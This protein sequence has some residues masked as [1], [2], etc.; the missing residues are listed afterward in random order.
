MAGIMARAFSSLVLAVALASAPALADTYARQPIDVM[1]YDVDIAFADDFAFSAITRIDVLVR[2]DTLAGLRL[3]LA[4]PRVEAV[5]AGERSLA[6]RQVPA[7]LLI[8]LDRP[9]ARGEIARVSVRYQGRPDGTIVRTGP[10]AHG[11]PVLFTDN[12]PEGARRWIPGIDHPSDKATV[13]FRVTAPDRFDVVAPGRLVGTRSLLDGR[14]LTH[15]SEAVPIPTYSMVLGLAE[16]DVTHFGEA[17]GVPLSAWAFPPDAVSAARKVART[18]FVLERFSDLLG[19]FPYEKLAQVQASTRW[20]AVEYASAIFYSERQL[21][22]TDTGEGAVAHEAAHQWWGDS[23]TPAD[24]DDVWLSEGFATYFDALF[25]EAVEGPKALRERMARA[26]EVVRA[27]QAKRPGAIVD[28][29]VTDPAEKLSPFTYQK[30]AWVLHML[31]RKLGE[32]AFFQGVREFYQTHAGGNAT[33]DDFRHAMEAAGGMPL[34]SFFREWVY[35]PG[36]P[37]LRI[38]W[39]W[40][41]GT[42]QAAVSVEQVQAA[43]VYEAAL[44]LAFRAQGAV[45]H[46]TIAL[47]GRRA[48]ARFAL[49]EKPSTVE[50]DPDGWL[51][52]TAT[53]VAP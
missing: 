23:V 17:D 11:R 18:A 28:P 15:W 1:H 46:R 40:D 8:D 53:V 51:L 29:A 4:G 37:E 33:T 42:R 39:G 6:F 50:V 41:E 32:Q 35:R 24:W 48:V 52:H 14:R 27:R 38:T 20:G 49:P 26:A 25:Y 30:G 19:P 34:E 31:R 13:D 7:A 21:E 47:K 3:D 36:L 10:N 2:G 12:W 44:D 22:G 5:T 43:E 45:E 16:F 9:Y